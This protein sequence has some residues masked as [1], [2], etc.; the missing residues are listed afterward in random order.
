MF[1]IPGKA[2]QHF[3][4]PVGLDDVLKLSGKLLEG[5][6][7]HHTNNRYSKR[8]TTEEYLI[9]QEVYL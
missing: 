8:R 9:F 4:L 7:H 3:W 2:T 5:L 1:S 6:Q